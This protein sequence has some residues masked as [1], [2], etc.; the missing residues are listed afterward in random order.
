M[1]RLVKPFR[2]VQPP[3]H[4]AHLVASRSYL[5]YNINE[6]QD[7]LDRN[8]YSYLQVINPDATNNLEAKRGTVDFFR[9]V[10]K[11]YDKFL[12]K[13]WFEG[14]DGAGYA[15]YRQTTPEAT[16][17]GVIAVL[18][19][20]NCENGG[21]LTHE[22]TIERREEL[23]ATY[24]Q[25]VGFNSEPILC[26]RN[27]GHSGEEELDRCISGLISS[28]EADCDF[29][30]TDRI[31]HSVWWVNPEIENELENAL[32]PLDKLYLADGHHRLASSIK[33]MHRHPNEPGVDR[34]LAFIVPARDLSI[35]GY[36]RELRGFDGDLDGLLNKI[37]QIE[38]VNSVEPLDNRDSCSGHVDIIT[39]QGE[40]RIVLE[41]DTTSTRIDAGWL[42]DNILKPIFNIEDPRNSPNLKYISGSHDKTKNYSNL[43][44][45]IEGHSDRIIF[46]LHP[47]HIDSII[48]VSDAGKTLPPKSTWV[49]P[50]LRSGLFVYEFGMQPQEGQDG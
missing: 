7:K 20:V 11:G 4:L 32:G 12:E 23:F 39:N 6:L 40:W 19:L 46:S 5:S 30:T 33:M 24:M 42:G 15:V 34:I 3:R 37:K 22:L 45:A 26:A 1:G 31:R 28:R 50:K 47:V 29:S 17:T 18:D 36:H 8:P 44:S 35:L 21:L 9:E 38:T 49:E 48:K 16:Y 43:K 27:S 14:T 13:G 2:L 25:T 41:K 10:R